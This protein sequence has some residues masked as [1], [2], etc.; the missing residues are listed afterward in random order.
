MVTS[1][2]LCRSTFFIRQLTVSS[3]THTNS[4][5]PLTSLVPG[6]RS[7]AA[8]LSSTTLLASHLYSDL[9][10]FSTLTNVPGVVSAIRRD[11]E[12][13][14]GRGV[15]GRY[16]RGVYEG[17]LW[18]YAG[19]R[20]VHLGWRERKLEGHNVPGLVTRMYSSSHQERGE[21]TI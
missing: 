20:K 17:G 9:T 1:P 15:L 2:H 11:P 5:P 18:R 6:L 10:L 4:R 13:R 7:H 12:G 3:S 8:P 16:R 14:G 21:G 19:G